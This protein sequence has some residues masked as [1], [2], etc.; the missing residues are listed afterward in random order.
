MWAKVQFSHDFI[1]KCTESERGFTN[2]IIKCIDEAVGLYHWASQF[3]K[4]P[5]NKSFLAYMYVDNFIDYVVI[6]SI[7]R[8]RINSIKFSS[9]EN[10]KMDKAMGAYKPSFF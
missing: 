2:Q 8:K 10:S 9:Q 4:Q 5:G 3:K 6:L 1:I 7:I